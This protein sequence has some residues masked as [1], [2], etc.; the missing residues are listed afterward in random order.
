MFVNQS[1]RRRRRCSSQLLFSSLEGLKSQ[2]GRKAALFDDQVWGSLEITRH[3]HVCQ[4]KD[5]RLLT[6]AT[7][8]TMPKMPN[9]AT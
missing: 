2:G 5:H 1:V 7:K 3:R 4:Q 9:R 6:E 8:Q